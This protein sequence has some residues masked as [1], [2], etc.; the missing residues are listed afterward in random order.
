MILTLQLGD[1]CNEKKQ[2]AFNRINTGDDV[3]FRDFCF[4][5]YGV[6]R[7]MLCLVEPLQPQAAGQSYLTIES[8]ATAAFI[9]NVINAD[10]GDMPVN[11]PPEVICT[12]NL[13]V[14]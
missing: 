3:C 10:S 4:C 11:D 13:R 7:I 6:I 12:G 8:T 2:A 1:Y 9:G 5:R 14:Y